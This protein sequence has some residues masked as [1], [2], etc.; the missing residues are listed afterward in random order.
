MA[1][2]AR[3]PGA[4]EMGAVTWFG[5]MARPPAVPTTTFSS[6]SSSSSSIGHGEAGA[7][8]SAG[9]RA[10][11]APAPAIAVPPAAAAAAAVVATL[12][13]T[14]APSEATAN[15]AHKR[16]PPPP[17]LASVPS[18][19]SPSAQQLPTNAKSNTSAPGINGAEGTRGVALLNA[20]EVEAIDA[21]LG[22]AIMAGFG[23]EVSGQEDV[24]PFLTEMSG[25][26]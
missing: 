17:L 5:P 19:S 25:D 9:G 13:R 18:P 2:V 3:Q 6:S 7:G 10:V 21:L 22:E 15:H 14:P 24:L 12:A 8:G 11:P 1:A 16:A 23:E 4:K 20:S 26:G